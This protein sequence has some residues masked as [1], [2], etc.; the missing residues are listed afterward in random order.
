MTDPKKHPEQDPAEGSRKTIE[1][2]LQRQAEKSGGVKTVPREDQLKTGQ[3]GAEA[4]EPSPG[5]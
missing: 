3:A 2:D 5:S 1:R 4:A